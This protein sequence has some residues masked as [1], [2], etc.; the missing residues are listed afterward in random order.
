MT[1]DSNNQISSNPFVEIWVANPATKIIQ[2][3]VVSRS[4]C[5]L[6]VTERS[7]SQVNR[8]FERNAVQL[9]K[10]L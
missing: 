8:K 5:I 7:H 4:E 1:D 9:V 3:Y 10:R 2:M 6:D